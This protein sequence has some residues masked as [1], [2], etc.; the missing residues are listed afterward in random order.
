MALK[1]HTSTTGY[2]GEES[3]IKRYFCSFDYW[4]ML[5]LFILLGTG[6]AFIYS[7]GM[8]SGN[9]SFFYKQIFWICVSVPVYFIFAHIDT[10]IWQ[11]IAGPFYV[12]SLLL[13]IT[14]L[15]FGTRI[16]GAKRWLDLGFFNFQP[17]EVA[18]LAL[19]VLLA[20]IFSSTDFKVNNF[21]S[22][23][24]TLFLIFLP[25]TLI[26]LEP[27]LGSALLM[28]PCS[29]AML[30]AAGLSRKWIFSL[31]GVFIL[32][33]GLLT[34][35]EY[36]QIKP[37]LRSYHKARILAFLNPEDAPRD[38]TYQQ[39]QSE[40]AV[41]SGGLWGKGIGKGTQHAQK[42]RE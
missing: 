21:L 11:V 24:V 2:P 32:L 22:L 20:K 19:I 5:S 39:R 9:D 1:F 41:G 29:G 33:I 42:F 17:S 25:F 35:N 16:S 3:K 28:L 10:R 37:L 14:V 27:D 18:K 6:L 8:Q 30:T 7:T 4:Q 40:L 38:M 15:I 36:F 31:L 13:L 34:V 12:I 23:S 26:F